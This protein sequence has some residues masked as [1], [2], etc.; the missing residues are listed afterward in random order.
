MTTLSIILG[1]QLFNRRFSKD[2]LVFMAEH[3]DLTEHY[4][5]HTHKLVLFL[6]AMRSYARSIENII[7]WRLENIPQGASYADLLV[8]AIDEHG[9]TR[10]SM[11]EIEDRFFE[12]RIRIFCDERG[13]E[14]EFT[15]NPSFLTSRDAFDAYRA[16]HK[17]LF[18]HEFYVWQRKRLDILMEG[19]VPRY[20]KWS[21][22]E[23]NRKKLPKTIIVP[24]VPRFERS[25]DEEAV[26]QLIAE[27]YPDH[28]GD[29]SEFWLPT[30]R[31][32]ALIWFEDFLEQR[33][34]KFGPY[35][36]ALSSEHRIMFHSAL[37]PLL[38]TG[39]LK[40]SEV[41]ERSLTYAEEHDVPHASL[42]GFVRQIIGWREF[43]RGVY[44]SEPGMESSNALGNERRLTSD[45]YEATTGIPPL[46]DAIKRAMRF[47]YLHHI[48][49]LMVVG[50][51]MNLT[52]IHP[53]DAYRWFME[54][55]VD[56]ADWV[57]VPNVYGM[58][59]FAD[60]AFTTKPYAAGSNYLLKMSDYP[61][62]PWCDVVDGLYWG[63]V[64][65]HRTLFSK[66]PRVSM[67]LSSL[68]R[69]DEQRHA[70]ISAAAKR[71]IET[72]SRNV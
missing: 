7:Y 65:R 2:T 39:L 38:N 33:F 71:F 44:R 45:W 25:E 1:D 46:D 5:Y 21:F 15:N 41:I 6:S 64:E 42:E 52:G 56:S 54:L 59:L 10:I 12:E 28:P 47:G 22:D 68:D 20:G 43:I 53:D 57:M 13:I 67:I 16:S 34:E 72:K 11:V 14:L 18:Q 69:M 8:R 35:E 30:T 61:R 58:A 62:G 37:S 32:R 48:E 36:D 17:R 23:E 66:N 24:G 9:I 51:L 40:P 63:F 50:N 49:R 60:D 26:I 70:R 27:R 55:F 19:S 29:P 3:P 31:E 4:R